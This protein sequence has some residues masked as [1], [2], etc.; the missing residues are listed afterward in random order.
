MPHWGHLRVLEVRERVDWDERT[1]RRR[2]DSWAMNVQV[3]D[4]STREEAWLV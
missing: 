4:A 1:K 3:M 2:H